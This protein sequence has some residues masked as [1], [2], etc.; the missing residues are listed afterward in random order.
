LMMETVSSCENSI[1]IYQT[2]C[3]AIPEDS[4]LHPFNDLIFRV[5]GNCQSQTWNPLNTNHSETTSTAASSS[6]LCS[7]TY[8]SVFFPQN[9]KPNFITI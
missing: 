3:C 2:T 9:K 6:Q 5:S 4:Y 8:S 7:Q 1:T